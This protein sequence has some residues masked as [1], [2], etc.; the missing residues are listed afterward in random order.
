MKERK[1]QGRNTQGQNGELVEKELIRNPPNRQNKPYDVLQPKPKGSGNAE[2]GKRGT[3]FYVATYNT[4]TLREREQIEDLLK[5]LENTRWN[6]VG[7]SETKRPGEGLTE[8]RD[9]NWIFECGKTEDR[10]DAKGIAF[11]IHKDFKNYVSKLEILSDR[12]ISCCI[13]VENN[14]SIKLI[15]VYAP[16]SAAEEEEVDKVYETIEKAIDKKCIENIIMGDFNAKIGVKEEWEKTRCIGKHGIGERNERGERLINFAEEKGLYIA[17]SFFKK[18]KNRYWTWESPNG[19][20]KN[21]IDYIMCSEKSTVEDC[22]VI[23]KVDIGSDHRM[24]RA[25]LRIDKRL[26]RL[27]HIRQQRPRKM[28]AEVLEANKTKFVINLKNRFTALESKLTLEAFNT[29]LEEES[30]KIQEGKTKAQETTTSE[31]KKIQELDK[32]RKELHKKENKTREEKVEYSELNKTVKKL[33]REKNRRKRKEMI[34]NTLER[35]KGPKEIRKMGCCKKIT[36]MIKENGETTNDR[37]EILSICSNFYKKLY[38]KTVEKPQNII[39]RSPEQEQVPKFTEDEIENTLK[40]LKKGKAP[41]IDNITSDVLKIGGQE[42]IKALTTIFNDILETQEIPEAWKEAKVIILHKKG[43][44]KDIKNY[45]PVS[46]LSHTYK[47]FTR[48]I[49][50]R[51]EKVLDENQPREQA[52]FRKKYSTADHLQAL[53][54]VIEKSEEYQLPLVIGFIDYEKAF[55]SVEHFSIFEA[56]RKI[57]VNETYVKILE[58]IYEGATAR[59]HLDNHISEPFVIER[60]VRQ[61]DPISPKLFTATIE[62]IFKKADLEKG[63]D[64]DGERLQNLRFADDVALVTETTDEM[65]EQLNKLNKESKKCGLK[66]HKGKTKFM[67]NFETEEEIK[68][69]NEKIE[70]V[71]SY[72]YLGQI[73]TTKRKL[74]DEVKERIRKT[75]S[76]FGKNREIFLDKTLPLSLKRQVFNQCVIPTTAYGCE[77]WAINKQQMTKLRSMQRAMERKVLGIKLKDKIPHHTIRKQTQFEDVQKHIGKQK[78]RWAGHL[79]RMKDNR[80]TKRCTEWQPRR[81]QRKRGR[82]TRRWRDDIETAAGKTWMRRTDDRP[83]WRGLS[84][85]YVL[86]WTD[87]A[88]K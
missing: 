67:T 62:E 33:K 19:E 60:G 5:E 68:I 86:Q 48:A 3:S 84:E 26:I 39:E 70:K 69:E 29:I 21:Q 56:L 14:K 44:R 79:G 74:E 78:W 4:R 6:V 30:N 18:N 8:M 27:K 53:N 17:N 76:C 87:E 24:V 71:E 36:G 47:L 61:G 23:P 80:W 81:G 15:Q 28:N 9:G 64:I 50:N 41:G 77:T 65:E 1:R 52:G 88:Y 58:N 72:N 49:Q 63:I 25:K 7:L 43:D 83:G 42:V 32:K 20:Y 22:E 31:E 57:N 38:T 35:G 54:Q 75:W 2:K 13:N 59:V 16:T 85:G 45:R 73:T 11:L 66:I 46:L 40:F 51:M 37:E 12:V 55:D 82:P 34:K 10:P